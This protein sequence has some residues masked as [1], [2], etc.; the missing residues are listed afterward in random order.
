MALT[1][2]KEKIDIAGTMPDLWLL[3]DKPQ[4]K[5]LASNTTVQIFKKGDIIY[6]ENDTPLH[7]MCLLSGKIKVYKAGCDRIQ[8][9]RIFKPF[10]YFAYRAAFADEEHRTSAAALERCEICMIPI[11]IIKKIMSENNLLA[12]FFI[13]K[14]SKALGT[15]D[16]IVVNLTQKHLRARLAETLITLKSKYGVDK[17]EITLNVLLSRKDLANISNMTTSNVIRTLSAFAAERLIIID[18][19]KIRIIDDQ[20][21]LNISAMG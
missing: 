18:G 10:E 14:L 6:S 1:N 21:L 16:K 5:E 3:L 17:D 20:A 7:F 19:K 12:L 8:I 11:S 4:Q 13:E 9:V 15:A 2:D